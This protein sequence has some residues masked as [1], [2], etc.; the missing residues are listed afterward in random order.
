MSR[1]VNSQLSRKV[2]KLHMR[3]LVFTKNSLVVGISQIV[4][5]RKKGKRYLLFLMTKR[6]L[7]QECEFVQYFV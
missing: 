1:A 3:I 4:F 7:K 5:D 6:I 2:V